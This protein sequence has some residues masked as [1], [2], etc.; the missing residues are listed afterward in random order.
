M[1]HTVI[2]YPSVGENGHFEDRF[3]GS[4]KI[5]DELKSIAENKDKEISVGIVNLQ[6]MTGPP[7]TPNEYFRYNGSLT[8]PPCQEIVVWTVF[9]KVSF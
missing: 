6:E 2:P 3:S 9:T 1:D 8:A 7:T 4:D 5:E